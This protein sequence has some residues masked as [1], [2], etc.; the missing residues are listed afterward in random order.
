MI[1]MRERSGALTRY[2]TLT[3]SLLTLGFSG[4]SS[5]GYTETKHPIVLVHGLSG[6]DTI[7]GLMDYWHGVAWNLERSGAKVYTAQVSAFN[8]SEERGLQLR[9]YIVNQIPE[10]KVNIFA[11]S[12]GSPTARVAASFIPERIASITSIGGANK[13][14][15]VADVLRGVIPPGG[16][17][18][19]GAT[20][21]L[22][23]FGGLLNLLSGSSNPQDALAA[24]ET[25][26]TAGSADLNT[27]HGWGV[28]T[29]S[30]C[31]TTPEN[32]DV[33]GNNIKM[34]SWVGTDVFTN[35]FDPSDYFL[36]T[37]SLAF[38]GETNDGLVSQCSQYLGNVVYNN[39]AMNHLDEVN[40]LFGVRSLWLNPISLY[41]GHANRLKNRGL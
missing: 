38:G 5:A 31:G 8:D 26:T 36:A 39:K 17:I 27:R 3:L 22:N 6:F 29:S 11:H 34:F 15:P 7:G 25:L 14:S 23:A 40:L 20:G 21:L 32:V 4:H 28:N 16:A 37:T 41:R 13:G 18:E 9:D 19:G 10:T 33:F 30:A 24:M 1:D 35:I 2:F 12:Q